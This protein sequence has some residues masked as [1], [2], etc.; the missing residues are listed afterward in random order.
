MS[1]N[2][3]HSSFPEF[4]RFDL[5]ID[6]CENT[7]IVI[8]ST[9]AAM[10][11]IV[12]YS[13]PVFSPIKNLKI[14]HLSM[15]AYIFFFQNVIFIKTLPVIQHEF[16]P[17]SGF[18]KIRGMLTTSKNARNSVI[19]IKSDDKIIIRSCRSLL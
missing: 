3:S 2:I 12:K 14:S 1:F 16:C 15:P 5:R 10:T 18:R 8:F 7:S 19:N 4:L 9:I 17:S 13:A 6:I 11:G